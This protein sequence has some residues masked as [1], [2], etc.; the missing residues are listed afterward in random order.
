[1]QTGYVDA[2]TS[3]EHGRSTIDYLI[4]RGRLE[5]IAAGASA[6]TARAILTRAGRR[7]GSA[8]AVLD[9]G[10]H[11]GAYVAAYDAYRMA[12]E[13]LL[14][15]QGLRA[16]GGD[17]SHV[18]VE[19]S[20]SAQFATEI[21]SFTKP[22]FECFRLTRHTAQY[23][24]PAAAEVSVEDALW[25]IGKAQSAVEGARDLS[26]AGRVELFVV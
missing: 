4:G 26:E 20:V 2:M 11:E 14:A 19:D 10:D 6:S 25:A 15:Q 8:R 17:G 3:W 7:L 9:T 23:F 5:Q 18:T 13:S 1:M 22:T 16:S 12:A 24:D 21:E